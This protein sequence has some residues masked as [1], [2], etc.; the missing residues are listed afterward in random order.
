MAEKPDKT[1][2]EY[3]ERI[4]KLRDMQRNLLPLYLEAQRVV[5]RH[6]K[7]FEAIMAQNSSQ[8]PIQL[9]KIISKGRQGLQSY[10]LLLLNI[11]R[12]LQ[13]NNF[14]SIQMNNFQQHLKYA[15]NKSTTTE[16]NVNMIN[17]TTETAVTLKRIQKS[18]GRIQ[19]L[20]QGMFKEVHDATDG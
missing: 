2:K 12:I 20:L 7:V 5:Q 9:E 8:I 6:E 19:D 10:R 11:H 1:S 13:K 18:K 14:L 3:F 16:A 17:E 15:Q 4:K